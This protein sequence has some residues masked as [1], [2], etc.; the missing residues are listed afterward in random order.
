MKCVISLRFLW[1][2]LA[3]R[4]QSTHTNTPNTHTDAQAQI[5]AQRAGENDTEY[6]APLT[7]PSSPYFHN[8]QMGCMV[9][10][11]NFRAAS[12]SQI[13]DSD[14]HRSAFVSA[15]QCYLYCGSGK[16]YGMVYPGHI[17][18]HIWS[19]RPE[20]QRP[21]GH[22]SAWC[23]STRLPT[24]V[25]R[26]GLHPICWDTWLLRCKCRCILSWEK[27]QPSSYLFAILIAW[28]VTFVFKIHFFFWEW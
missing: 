15:N 25:R 3:H 6:G 14:S 11:L 1:A 2:A 17:S 21:R 13:A 27:K 9:G 18:R 23:L 5:Q 22:H 7:R 26:R 28:S 16:V 10:W 4:R 12:K 24:A 19:T 20:T 8:K